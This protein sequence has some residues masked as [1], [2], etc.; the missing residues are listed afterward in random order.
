MQEFRGNTVLTFDQETKGALVLER[1]DELGPSI[2]RWLEKNMQYIEFVIPIENALVTDPVQAMF[3]GTM[4][5]MT[6]ALNVL[7]ER[8]DG[9]AAS[10][11]CGRSIRSA[12]CR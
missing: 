11:S 7:E 6:Q 10:P 8:R 3:C 4:A 5:R 2:Q 9:R 1:L 12:I